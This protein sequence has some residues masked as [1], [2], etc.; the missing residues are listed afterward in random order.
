MDKSCN[1]E[2]QNRDK[3]DAKNKKNNNSAQNINSRC[4]D[5][6]CSSKKGTDSCR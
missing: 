5:N 4:A 3:K 2:M 6:S 1:N